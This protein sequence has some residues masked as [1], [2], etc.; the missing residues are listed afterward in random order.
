[1]KMKNSDRPRKKSSRRSRSMVTGRMLDG[2]AAARAHWAISGAK[3]P[4]QLAAPAIL[5]HHPSQR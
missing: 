2:L 3:R 1:M 4:N 5:T